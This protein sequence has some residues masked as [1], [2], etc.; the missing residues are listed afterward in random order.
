MK[1]ENVILCGFWVGGTKPLMNFLLEPI[2][3]YLH[4]LST[5]GTTI[6]IG[7]EKIIIRAKLVLGVFDLPAK[8]AVL[9]CKQYNGEYGCHVCLNPGKRMPNNSRIYLPQPMY[10]EKTHNQIT[11]GARLAQLTNKS[12][13]GV[14]GTSS[15]APVLDLVESIP[16]DYMHCVLEG[17]TRW[18]LKAWT[19]SSYHGSPFYIGRSITQIDT[20][21]LKQKPPQEA[22]RPPRSIKKHMKYWKASELRNWLLYYSLPLLLNVLPPLYWHHYALL[23]CAMHIL[24]GDRINIP[25]IDAA[26]QM[27]IDFCKMLPELYGEA[28]CTANAHLLNHLTKYVRL[29]GPL[30]THSAFGFESKNG[31]LKHLFHGK[32]DI[33]N[34]LIFNV[35]VQNSLQNMHREIFKN[36][37]DKTISYI[38]NLTN[39][40]PRS[41]MTAIGDH[42]YAIGQRKVS[43]TTSEQSAVLSFYGNIEIFYRLMKDGI[44][45]Y[46]TGYAKALNSKRD[47][48]YCLY[49]TNDSYAFGRIQLFVLTTSPYAI[50]KKLERLDQSIMNQAGHPCRPSLH[51]YKETDLLNHYIV[52]VQHSTNICAISLQQI[53]SKVFIV[54]V[55]GKQYCILQPNSIEY[56]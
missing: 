56:H 44:L 48:T 15:L 26:E 3:S 32:S 21:L 11:V 29:W 23:V 33:L 45:Y 53:V 39:K 52:P 1:A 2:S 7:K 30:W 6:N 37:S 42:M 17:V 36:E 9:C 50:V 25:Q 41:T 51:I 40:A 13:L 49:L 5:I 12:M 43:V 10:P 24:L 8:A 46:C 31:H 38:S 20:Q 16:V 22:S 54:K 34:Q 28:S 27:L 18:L 35:N 47:N 4:K 55:L 19:D 14:N